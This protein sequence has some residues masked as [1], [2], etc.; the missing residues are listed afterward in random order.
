MANKMDQLA[1]RLSQ[2][3]EAG[4]LAAAQHLGQGDKLAVDGAATDALR[5]RLNRFDFSA[6]VVIGEGQKDLA[7]GLFQDEQVG[8]DRST[9]TFDIAV[10]PVDG[11][12]QV[13]VGGPD[14]LSVLAAG[15]AGSLFSTRVYYMH[16]V[17][18][19]P[20]IAPRLQD[21]DDWLRMPVDQL[22]AAAARAAGKDVAD[23]GVC[24]L[25]RPRHHKLTSEL[26]RT[27]CRVLLRQCDVAGTVAVALPGSGMDLCLGI[28]GAPETVLCAAALKCLGGSLQSMLVH[29]D[30]QPVDG[31]LLRLTDLVQDAVAFAAT[32]ITDGCLLH[33]VRR[34]GDAN[35]TESLVVSTDE[36]SPRWV[37]TR[38]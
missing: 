34:S 11:T 19:G 23:L 32:G 29:P 26:H 13:A 20:H 2:A 28:G 21:V 16:K 9:A 27:G 3:T 22:I 25:D 5:A 17:A 38:F 37:T 4:A 30:G 24:L 6:R 15:P 33:G 18:V 36:P 31:R 7:P 1:W 8:M 10:D 35:V 12:G 14:A